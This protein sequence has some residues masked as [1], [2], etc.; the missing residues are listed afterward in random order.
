MIIFG[1]DKSKL[2]EV[3][4][5]KRVGNSVVF[6]GKIMGS[7]PVSGVVKPSQVR[8]LFKMLDFRLILFLLTLPFRVD[9]K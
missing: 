9:T 3:S 8:A 1:G 7:M 5:L 4:E 2:M 6:K